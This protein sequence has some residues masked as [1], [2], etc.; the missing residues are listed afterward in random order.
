LTDLK[1]VPVKPPTIEVWEG[2]SS[3]VNQGRHWS[4]AF[5]WISSILFGGALFWAFNA[6]LDQT[7][8]VR[9]RLEPSGS[10]REIDSPSAGVVSKVIVKDGQIVHIG[11][12]LFTVEAKGLASRKIALLNTLQLLELQARSLQG[13]L[14]SEGDPNRFPSLPPLPLISDPVLLAQLSTAREQTM[15]LRAQLEQLQTRMR[16]RR[17]SLKLQKRL[18]AD[19]K[20]LFEQ[21][22]MAR[23]QYLTQLNTVQEAEAEVS[24][25]EAEQ[26]RLVGQAAG[27]LN[28]LNRQ[29]ISLRSELINLKETISYRT[30]KAPIDG[31]VFDIKLSS[32]SVVNGDQ[33]VLKIVPANRLQAKVDISDADIGFLKVG[34][35]ANVSI[36]SF[37]AGEFGYIRGTLSKL[38]SDALPPDQKINQYRFPATITLQQQHVESGGKSLNLQSGMSVSANIKLR[39]RPVITVITD[40]FTKQLEGVKRFR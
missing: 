1:P 7:I 40:M 23:S 6:K 25:L 4:S 19:L 30:I 16:S 12:P 9:G 21:G 32:Q 31:K 29:M 26:N 11:Q 20:P 36:D 14:A 3:Y 39:S 35:P 27:Q 2:S 34:L 38:G 17:T 22:G 33:N 24:T 15:Q 28:D 8:T 18:A 37:P 13:V 10:V 5:I